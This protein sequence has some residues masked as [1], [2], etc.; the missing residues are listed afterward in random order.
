MGLAAGYVILKIVNA[1]RRNQ[2]KRPGGFYFFVVVSY[3]SAL[4]AYTLLPL[5]VPAIMSCAQAPKP[6]L[7]PGE[8]F[9]FAWRYAQNFTGLNR[10]FNA[11]TVQYALNILLFVPL[12]V[13]LR[14]SLRACLTSIVPMAACISLSIEIIQG[15]N[16][17][18]MVPCMFRTAQADDIIMNVAGSALGGYATAKF[19]PNGLNRLEP[20]IQKFTLVR[21]RK[22]RSLTQRLEHLFRSR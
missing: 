5:S 15:T 2:A 11:Y 22:I 3:L 7:I 14:W 9:S 4:A 17:L 1:W 6:Q 12:G 10:L 19:L 18:G 21:K 8:S 20:Y 16:W 13:F